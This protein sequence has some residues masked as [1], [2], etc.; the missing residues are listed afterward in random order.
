MKCSPVVAPLYRL[1]LP[2]ILPNVVYVVYVEEL[3]YTPLYSRI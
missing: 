2:S 3:G 1:I